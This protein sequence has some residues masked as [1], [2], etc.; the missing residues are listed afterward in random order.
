M[1]SP[2][3][4][5]RARD[6]RQRGAND[7]AVDG[8][9]QVVALRGR[10]E[11]HRRDE[12]SV[13]V[14]HPDQKLEHRLRPALR[15]DGDDPLRVK[16]EPVGVKRAVQAR[17]PFHLAVAHRDFAV[18]AMVELDAIAAFFLG[19]VTR[20]VTR[21]QDIGECEWRVGD[22]H[23]ADAHTDRERAVVPD[24]VEFGDR[25]PQLV[26]DPFG[27]LRPN[28]SPPIRARVSPSRRRP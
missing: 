10:D 17:N 14:D 7:P 2:P 21:A 1:A 6:Q 8:G 4:A 9:H 15:A 22:E 20:G 12:L 11:G 13:F 28:S 16:A 3:P 25:L 19:H 26:R 27:V 24:E 18:L 5:A 23:Q